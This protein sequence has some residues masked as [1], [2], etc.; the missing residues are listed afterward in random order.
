MRQATVTERATAVRPQPPPRRRR[1]F[2]W[3]AAMAA[4]LVAAAAIGFGT[5]SLVAD[6][7]G[8]DATFE[9][10]PAGATEGELQWQA[11]VA[12]GTFPAVAGDDFVLTGQDARDLTEEQAVVRR[13]DRVTGAEEWTTE[14]DSPVAFPAGVADGVVV[15][16]GDGSVSGLDLDEGV[17]RWQ[18]VAGAV[19]GSPVALVPAELGTERVFVGGET[20]TAIDPA[21][22]TP[23]WDLPVEV[24]QMTV[25]E[26]FVVAAGDGQVHGVEPDS[27]ALRWTHDLGNSAPFAI[28]PAVADDG[29]AVASRLGDVAL[30]DLEDGDLRYH[31]LLDE[32]GTVEEA[33]EPVDR[34]ADVVEEGAE[35]SDDEVELDRAV[36]LDV[37]PE[38]GVIVVGGET[39]TVYAFSEG[40]GERIWD[41]V[42][43]AD[44]DVPDTLVVQAEHDLVVVGGPGSQD[45]GAYRLGDGLLAWSFDLTGEGDA[46]VAPLVGRDQVV[47]VADSA[48]GRDLVSL[49]PAEGSEQWRVGVAQ[50]VTAPLLAGDGIV[51]AVAETVD[52]DEA[53]VLFAVR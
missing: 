30:L 7:G 13:F 15:V 48:D 46:D 19:P 14:L 51:Y 38:A 28:P 8:D 27:G 39:G 16:T 9:Q 50:E 6:S 34:D 17:V 29:V 53:S 36:A 3:V 4:A 2:V 26:E 41:R 5:W 23:L 21:S 37:D 49:D 45:L 25:A 47:A 35:G 11:T 24:D 20:L 22:G 12:A 18:F 31:V 10:P 40:D 52:P 42:V 43:Q 1:R 33:T 44:L 32:L